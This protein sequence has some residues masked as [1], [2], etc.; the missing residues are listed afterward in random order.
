VTAILFKLIVAVG[1]GLLGAALL[2]D[3]SIVQLPERRFLTLAVSLQVATSAVLF[4]GLYIA[5]R[6][7]VTS[8]VPGYYVPA[9]RAV[10]AGLLPY[11][12]FELSYAPLFPYI[13]AALLRIWDSGKT[14]AVF[15]L[16]LNCLALLPWH[17]AATRCFQR[18]TARRCTL[19]YVTSGHLLIQGLLGTNQCWVAAALGGSVFLLV[20]GRD[21]GSGLVQALSL[22]STKFLVLLFWPVMWTCTAG[23]MRWFLAAVVPAVAVYG[24]FGIFGGGL[25]NPL[26]HEGELISSGN[27][28]FLLEPVLSEFGVRSRLLLDGVALAAL[29]GTTVWLFLRAQ[30]SQIEERRSLVFAGIVLTGVVF[31][32]FSKKSFTVYAIF[33]LYPLLLTVTRA[34]KDWR[35]LSSGVLLLNVVLAIEPSVWF[36]LAGKPLPLSELLRAPGG[37]AV[38]LFIALELLLLACYAS[39]GWIALGCLTSRIAGSVAAPMRLQSR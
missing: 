10:I 39:V 24:F 36:H 9:A 30:R 33:F 7:E 38:W 32:L 35:V 25:L 4:I 20:R 13:G 21:R 12:D 3:R 19:L 11:R 27:L 26:R 18:N 23:R 14:F 22:C 15:S 17:A 5:G 31:M 29:V 6:Q 37:A 28:P 34:L 1:T 16:L 8:D 2:R